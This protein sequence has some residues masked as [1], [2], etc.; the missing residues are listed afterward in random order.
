[1]LSP[2]KHRSQ[3]FQSFKDESDTPALTATCAPLTA[4]RQAFIV[5]VPRQSANSAF[6]ILDWALVVANDGGLPGVHYATC[7]CRD[8]RLLN[9][10][11]WQDQS[12]T[13]GNVELQGLEVRVNELLR[14]CDNLREEN[15]ALRHQQDNLLAERSTL[16]EKSELARS[17]V[18]SMIA[19]LKAMELGA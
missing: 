7:W 2:C 14:L 15:R 4:P 13:M 19:R 16:I 5:V 17:R 18:E 6:Q 3:T 12:V 1:M 8:C 9:L 11:R 10:P